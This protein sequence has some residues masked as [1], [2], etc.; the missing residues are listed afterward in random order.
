[1]RATPQN[2]RLCSYML[3]L[4]LMFNVGEE[5]RG[6]E[7]CYLLVTEKINTMGCPWA[8]RKALLRTLL[9][10][11]AAVQT[12][13]AAL[14]SMSCA[15]IDRRTKYLAWLGRGLIVSCGFGWE[16]RIR[17][18]MD[19]CDGL[20]SSSARDANGAARMPGRDV[21]EWGDISVVLGRHTSVDCYGST[22]HVS[23]FL[24]RR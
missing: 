9:I 23:I 4:I 3:L 2:L 1:M 6:W 18:W 22:R 16:G 13:C 11:S 14:D 24:E 7:T 8:L 5:E 20:T 21:R 17:G 10:L 12:L 15:S 19:T